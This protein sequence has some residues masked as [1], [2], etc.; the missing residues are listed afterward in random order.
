M[1]KMKT[2]KI[3]KIKSQNKQNLK[4]VKYKNLHK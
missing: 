1:N 3:N 4:K 2:R